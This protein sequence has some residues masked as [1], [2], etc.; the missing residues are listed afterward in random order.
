M[1]H[2][3]C[4]EPAKGLP[5]AHLATLHL[6]LARRYRWQSPLFVS[7]CLG[8]HTGSLAR[9]NTPTS[10]RGL[11]VAA[12][13]SRRLSCAETTGSLQFPRYPHAPMPCSQTP[14]VSPAPRPNGDG[15][16]AFHGLQRVGFP[17]PT[18]SRYPHIHEYTYFE[19]QSHGLVAC[20]PG[21]RTPHYWN[22]RRVSYGPAG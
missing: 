6:S 19:A 10:T 16:V 3:A 18:G 5:A 12:S 15:A 20:S 7:R 22:A 8:T 21:L 14:V 13:P 17:A 4:P 9:G 1:S 2:G 11:L